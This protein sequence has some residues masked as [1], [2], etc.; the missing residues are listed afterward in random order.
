MAEAKITSIDAI[1][2]F[3][4]NLVVY[5]GKAAPALDE[6][7][8]VV[9]RMRAWLQ[10]EQRMHWEGEIRHRRKTLEQAQAALLSARL[11]AL[12]EGITTEQMAVN[13]AKRLVE[14]AEEK[15][16]R[17]KLWSREFDTMVAPSLKKLE[18]L[19]SILSN[20]TPQAVAYLARTV[21]TLDAYVGIAPSTSAD[22]VPPPPRD[23]KDEMAVTSSEESTPSSDGN[24]QKE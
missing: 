12:R 13:R 24:G 11:S 5:V 17:V 21:R 15:L 23:T 20:D 4:A 16:R 14:E 3:R 1:E 2:A 8:E 19:R 10:D 7:G 6:I 22:S 18:S 9:R